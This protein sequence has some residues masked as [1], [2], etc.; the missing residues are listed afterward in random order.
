VLER[1]VGARLDRTVQIYRVNY[2]ADAGGYFN[3]TF[4][5]ALPVKCVS[6]SFVLGAVG[7]TAAKV[8]SGF[9]V[10]RK[11]RPPNIPGL[12]DQ[13]PGT[14]W[15]VYVPSLPGFQFKETDWLVTADGARY[16]VTNPFTQE[17]GATGSQL[18]C[19][20]EVSP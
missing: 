8:P 17:A 9:A 3:Q 1:N 7:E 14:V 15:S 13:A 10:D 6:G 4:D 12:P 20:R 2:L 19:E 18:L 5:A 11:L 16:R